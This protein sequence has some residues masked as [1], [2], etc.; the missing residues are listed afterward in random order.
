MSDPRRSK[1]SASAS[2]RYSLCEGSWIAEQA[3][4]I[5][6][7]DTDAANTGTRI[8]AWLANQPVELTES[9]LDTA[10]KCRKIEQRLIAD[11]FGSTIPTIVREQRMWIEGEDGPIFSGQPDL[12][13]W[14]GDPKR[15]LL[16]DYKTLWGDRDEADRNLQLRSLVAL[17]QHNMAWESIT[18]AICQPNKWPTVTVALY[19]AEAIRRA[20]RE[21]IKM[22]DRISNPAAKRTPSPKACQYCPAKLNC[23]E[24][25]G[26]LREIQ[27]APNLSVSVNPEQIARILDVAK[28]AE[29]II[30]DARTLAK[31]ALAEDPESI[32]GWRLK[33]GATRTTITDPAAVFGRFVALG[34]SQETFM[35]AVS[36]TVGKLEKQVKAVTGKKGKDL[37][38]TV[39]T[40]IAGVSETA[41]NAAS[42]ERV[43]E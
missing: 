4:G 8:H 33:P 35:P 15:G 2:L 31:A 10:T 7:P 36:V 41:Q 1:P 3:F 20:Y 16:I 9:E 32:P 24:A 25:G 5:R 34:G 43:Q 29:R 26:M 12:V 6:M 42:L 14:H 37:D 28:V 27:A 18:V 17:M 13:A 38:A 11:V 23:P 30:E 40:L 21:T 19:D 39:E 22:I